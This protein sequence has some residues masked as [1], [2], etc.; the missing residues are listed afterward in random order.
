MGLRAPM[1]R[2]WWAGWWPQ[3]KKMGS[4]RPPSKTWK[5][6]STQPWT[7]PSVTGWCASVWCAQ[8]L[9]RPQNLP[10]NPRFLGWTRSLSRLGRW[11]MSGVRGAP[12]G[13]TLSTVSLETLCT[14]PP[15]EAP[16]EDPMETS[17]M[18]SQG[19]VPRYSPGSADPEQLLPWYHPTPFSLPILGLADT[20][21]R[22]FE[23]I[24]SAP[25]IPAAIPSHVEDPG[26]DM[27]E[28]RK[29]YPAGFLERVPHGV[30]PSVAPVKRDWEVAGAWLPVVPEGD[31]TLEWLPQG[32]LTS[33][34][35]RL[36]EH[37]KLAALLEAGWYGGDSQLS[38]W[39]HHA[40]YVAFELPGAARL[41]LRGA[42]EAQV[43]KAQA[44]TTAGA[45]L[46]EAWPVERDAGLAPPA[47][48]GGNPLPAAPG[49]PGIRSPCPPTL[50][51]PPLGVLKK[52]KW[53]RQ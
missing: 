46:Q 19:S 29:M 20:T 53:G 48:G 15:T 14:A 21:Q 45:Y 28:L 2:H 17:S 35:E 34:E 13:T 32:W 27:R 11:A 41:S 4:S 25:S 7:P 37:L 10:Q 33:P 42:T 36:E 38:Q 9:T 50:G 3:W 51:S 22:L 39:D 30:Y 40:K 12:H 31:C 1:S 23:D 6:S 5:P 52:R 47:G 8:P 44:A 18:A 49:G 24:V 43:A 16:T 26:H